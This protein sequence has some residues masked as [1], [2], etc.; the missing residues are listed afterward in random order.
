MAHIDVEYP[1]R[2]RK[3]EFHPNKAGKRLRTHKII[4]QRGNSSG[5]RNV[6]TEKKKMGSI[7][8]IA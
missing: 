3:I 2:V 8:S 7:S 4:D 5:S 6:A 1:A